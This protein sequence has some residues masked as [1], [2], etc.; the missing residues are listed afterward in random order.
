M[1]QLWAK[2]AALGEL[3]ES[4]IHPFGFLGHDLTAITEGGSKAG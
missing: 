1:T 4:R 2:A 3:A